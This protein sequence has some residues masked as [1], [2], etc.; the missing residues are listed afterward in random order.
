MAKIDTEI[1]I[2]NK[3]GLHARAAAKLVTLASGFSS[4]IQL[5]RDTRAANAKS[6][7]G[8]MMLAAARGSKLQLVIEGEDAEKA[9][10]EIRRLVAD[11]FGEGE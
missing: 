4:D 9:A 8:V 11:R 7:M 6:I 1:T 3:L 10:N 2:V 5:R